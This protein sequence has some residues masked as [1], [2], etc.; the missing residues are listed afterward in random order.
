MCIRDRVDVKAV[1]D[2]C[3]LSLRPERVVAEPAQGQMQNRFSARIEEL[4]YLGD[5]IR[6]RMLVC[7]NSEFI[8]KVPN[9]ANKSA[10]QEGSDVTLGWLAE[11]CRALA[12]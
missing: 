1:G 3:T 6:A 10:L 2:R 12:T 11:D 9:S 7:G 5:H 8:V 4:I